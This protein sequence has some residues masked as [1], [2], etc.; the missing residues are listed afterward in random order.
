MGP[1]VVK[2]KKIVKNEIF[3][4]QGHILW[5]LFTFKFF[6]VGTA[7]K[8]GED[9]GSSYFKILFYKENIEMKPLHFSFQTN[10]P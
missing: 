4:L 10:M 9:G 3:L 7:V 6:N 1:A 8:I 2:D 5:I